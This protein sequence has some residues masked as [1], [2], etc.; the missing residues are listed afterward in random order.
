[1][2]FQIVIFKTHF[3]HPGFHGRTSI[4]VTLPTLIPELSYSDLE[5]AEGDSAIAAFAYLALGKYS[6]GD[7]TEDIRNNLLRYCE[8]DTLAMVKLHEKL[9]EYVT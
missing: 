5:I 7:E 4:K 9:T 1:M 6:E 2:K 3:N 8:R